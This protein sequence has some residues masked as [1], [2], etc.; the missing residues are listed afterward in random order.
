VAAANK[1][2]EDLIEA[3]RKVGE[4][5]AARGATEIKLKAAEAVLGQDKTAASD[6]AKA[7][8]TGLLTGISNDFA[9]AVETA[10]FGKLDLRLVDLSGQMELLARRFASAE[11]AADPVMA[12]PPDA[13]AEQLATLGK[14]AAIKDR[15]NETPLLAPVLAEVEQALA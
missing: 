4:A 3:I 2:R 11:K 9:S 8:V 1:L 10:E 7:Y 12:D 5:V 14:I 15:L 6:T 13:T